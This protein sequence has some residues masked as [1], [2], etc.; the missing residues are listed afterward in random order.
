MLR[1]SAMEVF[2]SPE[3]LHHNIRAIL[4]HEALSTPTP[5]YLMRRDLPARPA[6]NRL[7]AGEEVGVLP[8]GRHEI[9]GVLG[10]S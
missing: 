7:H 2:S 8:Q 5:S 4:A 1:L 10:V 9:G 3:L 6:P